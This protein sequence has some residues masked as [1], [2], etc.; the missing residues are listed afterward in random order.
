MLALN[1]IKELK[2]GNKMA[3]KNNPWLMYLYLTSR[4]D[5]N[6]E[7]VSSLKELEDQSQENL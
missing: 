2:G 7:R 3:L 4:K 1:D 6:L 5:I